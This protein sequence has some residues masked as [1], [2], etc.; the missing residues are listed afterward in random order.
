MSGLDWSRT[1]YFPPRMVEV[2]IPRAFTRSRF[3]G[4]V[5]GREQ[6]IQSGEQTIRKPRLPTR[7]R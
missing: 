5:P 4:E 3:Q 1:S 7:T 6:T 2:S